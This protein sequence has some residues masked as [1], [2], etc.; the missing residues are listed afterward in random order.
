M[1]KN[2]GRTVGEIMAELGPQLADLQATWPDGN[3]AVVGGESADTA[4]TFT[5]ALIAMLIAVVLIVGVLVIVFSSFRQAFIIFATMP[6]AIIGSALGFWFFDITFSF[7]AMI[8]LVSLIGIAIN[9]GIIM[10][11]T[12]NDYLKEGMAIAEA[13]AAGSARRLRPLLTTAVTTIV[14][15]V[16]LAISSAFYRP[17]TLVII[18]GLVSVSIFALIV[19]PALYLLLTPANAGR[20]MSLD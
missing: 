5:S 3:R 7:F 14:G 19:V 8:G 6:L 10:V 15:L 13:A 16:P 20:Y 17:L 9:N 1:A 12:M 4:E 18:F 2:E 11:D